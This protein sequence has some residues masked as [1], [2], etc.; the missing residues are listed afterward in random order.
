MFRNPSIHILSHDVIRLVGFYERL[1]FRETYRTPKEGAPVHVEVTLDQFT[2][3][4]SSVEVAISDHGLN[5][6]LDGHP[7]G[8]LLW[9]DDTDQDYARLISEGATSLSPPHTFRANQKELQS[10]WVA[11]PDGN[12]INLGHLV[13]KGGKS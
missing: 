3:G 9:T 13:S 11:D 4:I 10:A 12:P 7:I 6:D 8:I 2:I 5:P 1:G